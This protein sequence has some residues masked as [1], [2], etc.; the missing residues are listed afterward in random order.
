MK[1]RCKLCGRFLPIDPEYEEDWE[2]DGDGRFRHRV[3]IAFRRCICG[4]IQRERVWT[5]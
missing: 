1:P 5:R 4:E 2:D 3:M